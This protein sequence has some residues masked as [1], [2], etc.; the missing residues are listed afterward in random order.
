M[1][2]K[3]KCPETTEYLW[4][5]TF[6]LRRLF[7]QNRIHIFNFRQYKCFAGGPAVIRS[8]WGDG[9]QQNSDAVEW[10]NVHLFQFSLNYAHLFR[11]EFSV[12]FCTVVN[13]IS[14]QPSYQVESFKLIKW[15]ENILK[16]KVKLYLISSST[17]HPGRHHAVH[18]IHV[19]GHRIHGVILQTFSIHKRY[20]S[21]QQRK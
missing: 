5:G 12:G 8:E 3:S 15:W 9:F 21:P 13:I 6:T 16:K 4:I 1:G 11:L 18:H 19:A 2:I 20:F 14:V 10:M 17:S 7:D